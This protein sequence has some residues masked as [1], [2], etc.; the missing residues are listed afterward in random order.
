MRTVNYSD[1]L[2]GS[3]GLAGMNY[4]PGDAASDIGVQDFRLFRTFHD[5]RLQAAWEI[6]RWPDLCPVE[7]R[8]YRQLWAVGTT[9]AATDERFDL[10]S[11]KYFQSLHAT[12]LGNAPTIA[13]VENSAHWAECKNGYSAT[14]WL[15]GTAYV[16]GNQVKDPLTQLYYQ[17]HTAHTAGATI[18][19]T[20]MGLLTPFQKVIA[21]TQTGE[22]AIGEYFVASNKDPRITTQCQYFPFW[23]GPDGAVFD[24]NAPNTLWL[25]FRI[26]RPELIGDFWDS[27]A[28]YTSG[29]QAY[30]VTAAGAGN[31]YTANQTTA[32]GEDPET[33]PDKW[34]VVELPYFLRGYLI[35]AGLADWL[36]G[37]DR[38]EQQAQ[39][40][41]FATGYLELEADKLQRQQQ[42]VR[43]LQIA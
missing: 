29:R 23:L 21:Y 14:D 17:V 38:E 11:G 41:A 35:E 36:T 43:R 34:D 37:D 18:D 33:D 10:A 4:V 39:H 28:V 27:T 40:E 13:G 8:Y 3:A 32:A 24:V 22:T 12:N 30:F 2:R 9:Y 42:Q 16:V 19:L 25:Y 31:F 1:I 26:R 15:T 7:Q 6:H 5:R 20:K